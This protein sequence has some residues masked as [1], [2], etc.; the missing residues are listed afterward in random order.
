MALLKD[1]AAG[2]TSVVCSTHVMENLGRFDQVV[3]IAQETVVYRG[4]PQT[5]LQHFK[6]PSYAALYER[7]ESLAP[8]RTPSPAALPPRPDTVSKVLAG[9]PLV[10]AAALATPPKSPRIRVGSQIGVL[11]LRGL[12]VIWRD[13]LFVTLLAIQPLFIGLLINLS[14]Q[15]PTG[16]D[17][18]FLFAVV[19]SIWLGLNN[20]GREA[21]RERAIYVRERL[22]GVTPEGYLGAKVLLFGLV[23]LL[24]L[25]VLVFLLRRVNFLSSGDA[26]DLANWPALSLLLV[27]WITYLAAM[28]LGL[29]V[30]T[31]A[32]TQ[33]TAIAALPLIVLPQLLL[34]GVA[35]G[36]TDSRDASFGPLVLL[37]ARASETSRGPKGWLLE[38]VSMP[39]YS[40]PALSLLREVRQDQAPVPLSVVRLVDTLHMLLLLLV[41]ATFLVAAFRW[42]ERQWLERT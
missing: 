15:R 25:S 9:I 14:Q 27:L 8:G 21:V 40:R 32:N 36:L 12:L 1:L 30:S 18:I 10:K 16:L 7:L 31:L 35:T 3:V 20:T 37:G 28:L 22:V 33:E 13:K 4:S 5:L 11:F 23:G 29:L 17:P 42:R 2:R 38:V 24:Q 41:T 26:A 39:M 6:A 34:T 19:T